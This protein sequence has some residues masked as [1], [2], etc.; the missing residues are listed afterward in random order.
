MGLMGNLRNRAGLVIFVIGLAIVAFLLGDVVRS[1]SPLWMQKQNQVGSVDGN[2]ID[3]QDF[4][5]Q[6]EQVAN[7]FKQ[8]MGG[9]ETPQMKMYAVQQVWNQFVSKE[10]INVEIEKIGFTV[11][12]NELN[13]LVTGPNPSPQIAQTFINPQTGQ[14]DRAYLNQVIVESK[15]GNPEI[16]SQWETLLEAVK[17]QR[18][19]EKYANLLSASIYVTALEAQDEYTAKNKLANFKYALL[20]YNS[21]NTADVKLTDADYKEFYEKHKNSF[22]NEEETRG[23]QYILI[24]ARPTGKDSVTT[25]ASIQALKNELIASTNDSLFVLTNSESKFPVT[26]YKK[27]QLSPALDSVVFSTAVGTTVGPFSSDNAYEIAKVIDTKYSPD[28]V[29]VSHI[30]LNPAAEGGVTKALAKADSIKNLILKGGNFSSLAIEYSQDPN[31]KGNAGDMGT[32]TRGQLSQLGDKFEESIFAS[33]TGDIIVTESQVGVHILKIGKQVG[34]SKIVKLAIVDKAINAGK[35]TTDA[36]YTKANNFF[37][38]ANSKNFDELAKKQ[39]LNLLSASNVQAMDI[40]INGTEVP[41]ELVRWIFETK[42]NEVTDKIYETESNFIVAKVT[43]IHPKGIQPLE[44]VKSQLTAGVTKLVKG[45]M[46][47]EKMNNALNGS[48]SIDQVAQKLNKNAIEVQN[49]VLANPVIPGVA[50][51]SAVI[52]TV[53]GL[54]PNKPSKPVEGTEGV[55]VVQVSSFVNPK[56]LVET[57][58]KNQQKQMLQSKQQRAWGSIFQALKSNADID[59]NRI[60]FY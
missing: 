16:A 38:E 20:D 52:G 39:N 58:R 12:K 6:V 31:S 40:A 25:L 29:Q 24:D 11:G 13:D 36:A 17:Q 28:S 47:T 21:I 15:N 43:A 9:A 30:V 54:Q 59:D 49:I 26:Y 5:V 46:L 18:L 4:N 60:R 45:R 50:L 34:N 22:K 42:D 44:A 19:S 14:F 41:R 53:F 2:S 57:E 33:K 56:E 1:G 48:A 8:Q 23:I 35:E 10:L 37:T 55:Y 32:F 27:G 3:Y 7:Q 51:E